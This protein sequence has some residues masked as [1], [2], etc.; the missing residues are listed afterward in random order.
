MHVLSQQ[1][2]LSSFVEEIV[3]IR[4]LNGYEALASHPETRDEPLRTSTWEANQSHGLLVK[5]NRSPNL[6]QYIV[7]VFVEV[8]LDG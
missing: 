7:A 4:S 6:Q 8:L 3:K 1:R 2:D 5:T